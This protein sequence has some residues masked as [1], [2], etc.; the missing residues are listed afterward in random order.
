MIYFKFYNND[1]FLKNSYK[2][3]YVNFWKE[4]KKIK[5]ENLERIKFK[6]K[7]YMD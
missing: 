1:M 6:E 4:K 7:F 2:I 3:C 5:I